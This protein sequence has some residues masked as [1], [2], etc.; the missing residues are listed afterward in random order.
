MGLDLVVRSVLNQLIMKVIKVTV[1]KFK[2]LSAGAKTNA[3][4]NEAR[5]FH[6]NIGGSDKLGFAKHE[7]E[8]AEERIKKYKYMFTKSGTPF[9]QIAN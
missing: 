4:Y 5:R 9:N 8:A 7:L 1:Y 3:I 6:I 2:E